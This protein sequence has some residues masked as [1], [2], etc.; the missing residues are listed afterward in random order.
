MLIGALRGTTGGAK[1]HDQHGAPKINMWGRNSSVGGPFLT[2]GATATSLAV[3]LS[4]SF[5]VILSCSAAT[6][7]IPVATVVMNVLNLSRHVQVRDGHDH[8]ATAIGL[9]VAS[10]I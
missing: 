1:T 3:R 6:F 7:R 2:L 4:G 8:R 9:I 5:P 10:G